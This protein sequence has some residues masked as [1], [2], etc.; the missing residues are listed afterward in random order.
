MSDET[1]DTALA[2]K[3]VEADDKMALTDDK[4]TDGDV[5]SVGDD[6]PAEDGKTALSDDKPAEKDSEDKP[7]EYT[8]FTMPEGMEMDKDALAEVTPLMQ[9]GKLSQ[10]QAQKF[11]DVASGM[12]KKAAENNAKA[13][14]EIQGKWITDAKA[15]PEIG[16]ERYDESCRDGK[17]AI[18]KIMGDS[19]PKLMEVLNV[20]GVGDHPE[21][22]R[23]FS[24]VG[25]IVKSDSFDFGNVVG[26]GPKDP[27][28]IAY[29]DM[30]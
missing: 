30:K 23:F 27:A 10:E 21:M 14:N 26:E 6:K 17:L 11:V 20:T 22:I 2:D 24:K 9:E 13:W 18:Q 19:A 15:D 8:D 28:K 3:S 12:V 16:G 29:P 1:Q 5:Q 7:V 4:P 25:A